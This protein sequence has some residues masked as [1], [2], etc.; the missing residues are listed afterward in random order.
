MYV[1]SETWDSACTCNKLRESPYLC[2]RIAHLWI[3]AA[4]E[5][6]CRWHT[7]SRCRVTNMIVHKEAPQS[8]DD[9]RRCRFMLLH[10]YPQQHQQPQPSHCTYGIT[11]S[12]FEPFELACDQ[13]TEHKYNTK[14]TSR[15]GRDRFPEESVRTEC[16]QSAYIRWP[17]FVMVPPL[18]QITKSPT[19]GYMQG[20]V[21]NKEEMLSTSSKEPAL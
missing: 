2:L 4:L 1:S 3:Y 10:T 7:S 17:L 18:M 14:T 11:Y 13:T 6:P 15:T 19:L 12:E 8:L 20:A 5:L 21:P 9:I 16:I